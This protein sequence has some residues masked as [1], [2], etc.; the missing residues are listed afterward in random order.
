MHEDNVTPPLP[1]R[2]LAGG[3]VVG[4]SARRHGF[5]IADDFVAAQ[6][7]MALW[8]IYKQSL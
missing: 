3:E 5:R 7:R 8:V 2:K 4:G 6:L 1:A